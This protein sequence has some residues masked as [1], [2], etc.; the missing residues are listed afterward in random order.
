MRA[1]LGFLVVLFGHAACGQDDAPAGLHDDPG[2]GDGTLRVRAMA[3]AEPNLIDARMPTDFQTVFRVSLTVD[4]TGEP[5]TSGSVSITSLAGKIALTV[6][7]GEWHGFAP[8]YDET[9]T[10]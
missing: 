3:S 7:D 2:T 1:R 6:R 9:Y 8:S 4:K 10:L 5:V